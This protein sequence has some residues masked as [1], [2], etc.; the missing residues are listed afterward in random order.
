MK[1]D[2]SVKEIALSAAPISIEDL[3][4]IARGR[5]PVRLALLGQQMM[6]QRLRAFIFK[7]AI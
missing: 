2:L 6:C 1:E 7:G 5:A 4:A 3:I